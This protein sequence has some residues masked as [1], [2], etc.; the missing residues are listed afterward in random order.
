VHQGSI[1]VILLPIN[2]IIA[3]NLP[4]IVIIEK[5][6]FANWLGF[7]AQKRQKAGSDRNQASSSGTT[8]SPCTSTEPAVTVS[9]G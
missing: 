2:R 7:I 8:N 4:I 6:G 5:H 9:F 3:I 1:G